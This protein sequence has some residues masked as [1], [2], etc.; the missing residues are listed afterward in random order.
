VAVFSQRRH[1]HAEDGVTE[2]PEKTRDG[3]MGA[4]IIACGLIASAAEASPFDEPADALTPGNRRT[5]TGFVEDPFATLVNIDAASEHQILRPAPCEWAD[6]RWD[7]LRETHLALTS[8]RWHGWYW[9]GEDSYWEDV[10]DETIRLLQPH[11]VRGYW[12]REE[13]D[14]DA[15]VVDPGGDV[16]LT[17]WIGPPSQFGTYRETWRLFLWSPPKELPAFEAPF[18]PADW[19]IIEPLPPTVSR[20][21]W[22]GHGGSVW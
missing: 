13:Y 6:N 14:A 5:A 22:H 17:S 10:E 16:I 2:A 15:F 4:W 3:R 18:G 1:G 9:E 8:S 11:T 7:R 20:Q 12:R 21:R 19:L